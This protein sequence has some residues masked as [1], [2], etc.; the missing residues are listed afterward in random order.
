VLVEEE[1]ELRADMGTARTLEIR[2]REEGIHTVHIADGRQTMRIR[3]LR[4][5]DGQVY[6]LMGG[7]A[8]LLEP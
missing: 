5:G 1:G 2:A 4:D 8:F 3:L 6:L 7:R